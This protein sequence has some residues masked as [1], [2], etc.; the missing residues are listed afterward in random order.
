MIAPVSLADTDLDAIMLAARP[1]PIGQRDA[2][3]RD[4]AAEL[5]ARPDA[6]IAE[7]I[8]AAQRHYLEG[9]A[10]CADDCGPPRASYSR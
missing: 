7:I 3:L 6:A 4:V 10:P 9:R 1:L 8:S 5:A 2:F